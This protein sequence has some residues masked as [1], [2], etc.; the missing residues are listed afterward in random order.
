MIRATFPLLAALTLSACQSL[1]GQESDIGDNIILLSAQHC[2][3]ETVGE[4]NRIHFGPCLKVAEINGEKPVLRSD[5]FIALPVGQPA[6]LTAAC[7]YRH[8]DGTLIPATM[9]TTTFEIQSNT[10]TQGGQRWYLHAHTQAR[11]I[12]GCKPTL[13][14]SI[15]PVNKTN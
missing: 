14:R 3:E 12:I 4:N 8:A 11:G 2:L 10:F 6:T 7:V 9:E 5:G 1:P 15:Y 13:S